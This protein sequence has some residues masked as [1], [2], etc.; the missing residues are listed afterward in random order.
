MDIAAL[1]D[2]T[3]SRVP[4]EVRAVLDGLDPAALTARPDPHANTIAWLVWHL[5][6]IQDAQIAQ[7]A[8]TE[9]LWTAQG[10][11]DRFDLPLDRTDTGFGHTG[12][13]VATVQADARLL[14]DYLGDV[15]RATREYL[16]ILT[17]DD[18]DQVVDDSWDPPVTLG[19]RL[20]SI[21][22]DDLQHVGQAAYVRGLVERTR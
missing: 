19:A 21:V 2:E 15:H 3:Y 8:G 14:Q 5:A 4:D 1:L 13:Q 10:W 16:K 7:V 18:L 9:E 12:D 22:A 17:A 20:V 11:A 6:R